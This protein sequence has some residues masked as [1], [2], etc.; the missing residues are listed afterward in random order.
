MTRQPRLVIVGDGMVGRR[1]VNE[2]AESDWIVDVIAEERYAAYDRVGLSSLFESAD[3]DDLALPYDND[4]VTLHLGERAERIDREAGTVSTAERTFHYDKLVLATGSYSFVPPVEGADGEGVFVYRTIDDVDAIK[5]RAHDSRHGVVVGGGLLGLEAANALR[6]LGLEVTIL[7]F[8]PWLMARQLDETGGGL[9]AQ[10]IERLGIDVQCGTGAN[11]IQAHDGRLDVTTTSDTEITTD[12]VV[13]AA[14]V[15]PRDDLARAAGLEIGERGGA[16]IDSRCRTTDPN[17]FAIGEVASFEGVCYGLVAPGYQM[18]EVVAAGLTGRDIEFNGADTSTKLKLLGVDVSQFGA[19]DG[20]LTSTYFD[21][22]SGVY[23]KLVLSDDASELLGGMLVGDNEPYGVLRASV[24]H[25]PPAALADLLSTGDGDVQMPA[26]AQV[27]SCN[28]VTKADITGAI[29]SGCET[30]D[31]LKSCTKAGTGCG[32][33]L[34][35]LKRIL[36]DSGVEVSKAVCEHFEHTRAELFDIVRVTGISTFSELIAEYGQGSGCDI[37]KP[38]VASILASL[39][40]GH[41]LEGEQAS[42]QDTNDHFLA[43]MQR[44][45]TYSVVPRI[46]GG[47]VTPEKLIVIGEVAQDFDLYT[48]ITGG[49][50]IDLLGARVEDLPD[51]WARLVDAGFES[52]HAYGKAVR[53]VK[54]CVGTTWC[55]YGV[56]DSVSM[57][58]ELELR[59][60]GLRSP[61]KIKGAVS[62]CAR[63][64]AEARSKDFGVI[65]TENGWN[66]YVGGNGGFTPR[67]AQLFASDLTDEELVHTIDRFIAFYISTA[68]RLMRTAAWLEDLDGGLDYLHD[69]IIADKLGICRQLD[70]IMAKHVD[71]YECEWKGVLRDQEKLERFTSFINAPGT[72]D[73]DISFTSERGQKVPVTLQTTGRSSL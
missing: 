64:C 72:P 43:N 38:T 73:P 4:N 12:M 67:H 55:R 32:S 63:E 20:P 27:C 26:D 42:L 56:Q 46:P 66:L 13:F 22:A 19:M 23:A 35:M 30:V 70:D 48:K 37:C 47:E 39:S 8:A 49:Q 33:C 50:R 34:P 28:A 59:Y 45:G 17:V 71:S 58:I 11:A 5:A 62:G 44:N 53:T 21:P 24:G 3:V 51:I 60:R 31:D 18:A 65:A 6:L 7:E 1:L 57:A 29:A 16:T 9:L 36:S 41:I 10:T 25:P 54:S 15:R 61:H 2:L 68:D 14:G 52:G 40:K 69:V